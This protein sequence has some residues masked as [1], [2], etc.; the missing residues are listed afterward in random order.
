LRSVDEADDRADQRPL[1]EV[2]DR[3]SNRER[4]SD[5]QVHV[6]VDHERAHREDA[7]E[8]AKAR[9]F[10]GSRGSRRERISL[11]AE[12]DSMRRIRRRDFLRGAPLAVG[13]I[14]LA[15]GGR[16][17]ASPRG[18]RIGTDRYTPVRD[19]P[20]QPQ[21]YFKVTLT[22]AFWRPKVATNATVTIP[23]QVAK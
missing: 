13:A 17:S 18:L 23:F 12:D 21:P 19:Y 9:A 4:E 14:S 11:V 20:I 7:D 15:A 8:R 5:L 22:D 6:V 10:D 1:E 16:Q 2:G 3:L